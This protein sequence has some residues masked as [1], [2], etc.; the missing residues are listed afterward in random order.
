[1]GKMTT[2]SSKFS[3]FLEN[4]EA[5]R[6]RRREWEALRRD[7]KKPGIVISS[8]RQHYLPPEARLLLNDIKDNAWA[9]ERC[10][11]IG[12][13]PS[14]KGF[15]FSRLKNELVIGINRAFEK[16]DCTIHFSM[17]KKFYEWLSQ[18]RFGKAALERFKNFPGY[19][20]WVDSAGYNYPDDIRLVT[21][22][23]KESFTESLRDGL[24]TGNNSGY[25][26]LNLACILGAN[27]IY[28]L[29][30][31]MKSENKK[32][33]WWHNGYPKN[34]GGAVYEKFKGCFENAAKRIKDK[35]RVVNLNPESGLRCFK[36]GTF[37]EIKPKKFKVI[38]FYT[39]GTSYE[40]ESK[41]MEQSLRRWN[42]DYKIYSYPPLGGWRKNLN[43]K[44]QTIMTAL[45][46]F[47]GKDIVFIDADAVVQKYPK[48]FTRLSRER[49]ETISAHFFDYQPES[50]IK[51]ELLSGTLW[52]RNNKRGKELIAKWHE[53]ALQ[54]P[55][56]IHQRC[57]KFALD[58]TG[59][60]P[61]RHPFEYT[62]IWDYPMGKET[63]PVIE[64]FQASR[65]HRN[66]VGYDPGLKKGLIHSSSKNTAGKSTGKPTELKTV[67]VVVVTYRRLKN[68]GRI[69][70]AW[71][72]QIEDVWL[73]DC[74]KEGYKGNLDGINVIRATPDPGNKIRH[75]V[76]L[77]TSGDLVIKADDD[78]L[79]QPGLVQDFRKA[80][81]GLGPGIY[82]IHGRR[83]D[84][85]DYYR[86]T[87]LTG[88]KTLKKP[89]EVD[90][91]GVIT[92]AP[93]ELLPMDLKGCGT[94][95][96]DLWWQ[97]KEYPK[98]KKFVIPTKNFMNLPEGKDKDRL[99]A[100]PESRMIRRAFYTK[101][102]R[103]N[104]Q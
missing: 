51:D 9:G 55:K 17:D 13:G 3:K 93:R 53:I 5:E 56:T 64:H 47:P 52:I 91:V 36:F 37:E 35:N 33:T 22:A 95:I 38:S 39:E 71:R 81:E 2:R 98:A 99:C 27:P 49:K 80:A 15:D 68:L 24:G 94:P 7:S 63:E 44:S 58:E 69:L 75:A 11:I 92:C 78:I 100:R 50:G 74:S 26:A 62:Y 73:C 101:Y 59:I 77:L 57:L 16:I 12:G 31:D 4:K 67:S 14:L 103:E 1:M 65:K 6:K 45:K 20:V 18:G 8:R 72:K 83:F 97:M 87:R 96:E 29:G 102:Y 28:L 32:Q 84:G 76:A 34:Q 21:A 41:K 85:P 89:M 82:S 23:G 43:Y 66:E 90:F 61:Y 54:N 42:L 79:P 10:F 46:E 19:R 104:Y 60:K 48:L 70:E 86:N 30:F 40:K 88:A 25:A